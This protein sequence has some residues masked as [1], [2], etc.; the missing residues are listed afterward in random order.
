MNTKIDGTTVRQYWQAEV[1]SLLE[2]YRQ[3]EMLIPNTHKRKKDGEYG[4]GS[5]HNPE[6]GRA[7]ESLLRDT[8]RK[9]L[10]KRLEVLTGFISRLSVKTENNDTSRKGKEDAHSGQ[11]DII[12]YDSYNYPLLYRAGD[13]AVVLPE[14]VVAIISVKKNLRP[15]HVQEEADALFRASELCRHTRDREPVR[16][17]FLALIAMESSYQKETFFEKL[18]EV[19]AG[20]ETNFYFD[21]AIGYM[22]VLSEWGIFKTPPPRNDVSQ[23]RYITFQFGEDEHHSGLQFLLNGILSVL[24]DPSRKSA[25]R[26]GFTAFSSMK[27]TGG[28]TIKVCGLRESPAKP[29]NKEKHK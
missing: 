29:R 11:L 2:K 4:A 23:A 15:E 27:Y 22:G 12:V 25:V 26:P 20:K 7:I 28:D 8:L 17:P 13:T 24:Y 18:K 3:F 16:G 9:F 1:N 6:D 10:P 19:Y 14:G 5:D 21:D